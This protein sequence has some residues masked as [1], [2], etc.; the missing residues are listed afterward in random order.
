[1][2]DVFKVNYTE[3]FDQGLTEDQKSNMK[4]F[5]IYRSNPNDPEDRP[6]YVSYYID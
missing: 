5:D 2:P 1:M 4:R 6:K 3:E